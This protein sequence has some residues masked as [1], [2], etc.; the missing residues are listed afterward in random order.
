MANLANIAATNMEHL[1]NCSAHGYSQSER[2]GDVAK[3]S[4]KVECEG[5]TSTFYKGDRDCSSGII[6]S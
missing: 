6:D 3:G 5:H 1:C 2:W 4:C